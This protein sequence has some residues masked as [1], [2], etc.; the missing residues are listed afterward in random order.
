MLLTYSNRPGSAEGPI[1]QTV[2]DAFTYRFP[3]RGWSFLSPSF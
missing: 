3:T 1:A 2:K